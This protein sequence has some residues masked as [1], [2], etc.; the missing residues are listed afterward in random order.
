MRCSETK[1]ERMQ[2]EWRLWRRKKKKQE[3]WRRGV[4]DAAE[5]QCRDGVRCDGRPGIDGC[6]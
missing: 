4:G 6:G 2:W 3:G 1:E 5:V